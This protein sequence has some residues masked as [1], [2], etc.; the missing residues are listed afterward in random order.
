MSFVESR[1]EGHRDSEL[2]W[3]AC[4]AVES[5]A[6]PSVFDDLVGAACRAGLSVAEARRTVDSARRRVA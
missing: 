6:D 2:Y 1:A 5:G 4:R 3:A